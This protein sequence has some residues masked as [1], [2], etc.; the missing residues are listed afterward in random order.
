MLKIHESIL[1][2]VRP[3]DHSTFSPSSMDRIIACPYSVS[4]SVG[5]PSTSS[6]YSEE[7]TLAHSVCEALFDEKFFMIPFPSKLRMDMVTWDM[8]TPGTSTEMMECA[9]VYVNVLDYWIKNKNEIG[10]VLFYGLE[11]GIPIFPEDGC[12]GTADCIIIGTKGSAIIDYKHGKGK[13]VDADSMQLRSYAAG[14]ARHLTNVPEDYVY[15]SVVV[16]PRTDFAPKV[17]SYS[18]DQMINHLNVIQ[19]AIQI[20]RQKDLYPVEGSHCWFCPLRQTRDLKFKCEAIKNK[21]LA[22]ANEDFN[23]FLSDMSAPVEEFMGSNPKR[24]AAIIKIM[25]LLPLMQ[26]IAKDGEAE[27]LQRILEGETIEGL[28]VTT[29]QGNRTWIHSDEKDMSEVLKEVY[30]NIELTKKIEKLKTITEIE[31]EVGKKNFRPTLTMRPES[32]KLVIQDAKMRDVL[33]DLSNFGT[34]IKDNN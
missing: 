27:M 16:Q 6:V 22:L 24:D 12:F 3:S 29:K 34:M 1:N 20:S 10:E 2:F 15:Y 8:K 17:A 14:I 5:V 32:K 11:K 30:P 4:K 33:G 25:S 7:G 21:S 26:Q 13:A 9:E 28:S 23:K 19:Q 31:K 18:H